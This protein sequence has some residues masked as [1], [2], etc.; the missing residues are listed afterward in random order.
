MKLIITLTYPDEVNGFPVTPDR[1]GDVAQALI[2]E[3]MPAT[4]PAGVLVTYDVIR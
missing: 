1:L 2:N 3:W 4:Y